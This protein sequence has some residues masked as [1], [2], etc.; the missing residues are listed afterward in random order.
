MSMIESDQ[1]SPTVVDQKDFDVFFF[2]F[3]LKRGDVHG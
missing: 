2:F 3:F 1:G